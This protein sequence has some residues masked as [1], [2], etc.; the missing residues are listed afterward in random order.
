MAERT[1]NT[2]CARTLPQSAVEV[3]NVSLPDDVKKLR[4]FERKPMPALPG[5]RLQLAY[6]PC[7]P[8]MLLAM[9]IVFGVFTLP[10]VLFF[11]FEVVRSGNRDSG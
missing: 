8:G 6:P 5:P 2:V 10:H 3:Q 11:G 7:G 9:Q 4:E 1:A